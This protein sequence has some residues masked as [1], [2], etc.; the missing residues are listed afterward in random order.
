MVLTAEGA[1]GL[2]RMVVFEKGADFRYQKVA[3]PN[4]YPWCVNFHE[5]QPSCIVGHVLANLGLTGE[6]AGRWRVAGDVGVSETFGRLDGTEFGWTADTDAA[7]ILTIAQSQQD[8][9]MTWGEALS[10]AE[11]LV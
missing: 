3:S 8:N 4:G 2:L 7:D 6:D 9:G 10:A 1:I 5:G 11:G